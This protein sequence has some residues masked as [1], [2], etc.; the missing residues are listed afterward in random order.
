M[1]STSHMNEVHKKRLN[2][3]NSLFKVFL[4]YSAKVLNIFKHDEKCSVDFQKLR[5]KITDSKTHAKRIE[6]NQTDSVNCIVIWM[7]NE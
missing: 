4:R 2:I 3:C 7:R 5:T 6:F 1:F